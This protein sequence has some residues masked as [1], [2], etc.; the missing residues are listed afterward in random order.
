MGRTRRAQDVALVKTWY[1]EHCPPNLPVKVRVSY[2]KLPKLWVLNELHRRPR[3]PSGRRNLF[4]A[5][6]PAKVLQPAD[7]GRGGAG[8][9]AAVLQGPEHD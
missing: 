2:Q 7:R 1:R 8:T 4:S 5:L 9:G 6:R 3:K